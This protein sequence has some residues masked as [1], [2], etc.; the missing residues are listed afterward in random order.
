MVNHVLGRIPLPVRMKAH[1]V[2]VQG[3]LLMMGQ[4]TVLVSLNKRLYYNK[5]NK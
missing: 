4:A 3:T 2:S 5:C 1:F